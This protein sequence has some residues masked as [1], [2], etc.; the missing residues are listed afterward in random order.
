MGFTFCA[1]VNMM[2]F[3]VLEINLAHSI[4]IP[5]II[6]VFNISAVFN[7]DVLFV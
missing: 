3:D 7:E 6:T 1:Y 4:I 2:A 5:L